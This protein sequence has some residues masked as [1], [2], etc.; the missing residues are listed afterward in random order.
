MLGLGYGQGW[1]LTLTF[2]PRTAMVI[3]HIH[4]NGQGQRSL[5][6]KVRVET[7][8]WTETIALPPVLTPYQYYN[9]P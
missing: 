2:S 8:D 7:D 4:A 1:E 6:S 3:T 9:T 5:V